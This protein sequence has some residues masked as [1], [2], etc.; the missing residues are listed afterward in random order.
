LRGGGLPIEWGAIVV[1]LLIGVASYAWRQARRVDILY[2]ALYGV[3]GKDGLIRRW[4]TEQHYQGQLL[5]WMSS[6][7]I[8]WAHENNIEIGRRPER[9]PP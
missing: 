1:S 9:P 2:Q 8:I 4:Q 6:A 5:H 7:L 3:E